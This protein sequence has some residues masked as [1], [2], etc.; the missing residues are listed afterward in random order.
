M[1]GIL[2]IVSLLHESN[3]FVFVDAAHTLGHIQ[4]DLEDLGAD[5]LTSNAHKW[6]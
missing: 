1:F 2:D 4:M 6:M 5:A 3:I